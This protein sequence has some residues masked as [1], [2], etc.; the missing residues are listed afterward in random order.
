MFASTWFERIWNYVSSNFSTACWVGMDSSSLLSLQ[1][2]HQKKALVKTFLLSYVFHTW[3]TA[4]IK[5]QHPSSATQ[6][7]SLRGFSGPSSHLKWM[8]DMYISFDRQWFIY[9]CF[10]C[11]PSCSSNLPNSAVQILKKQGGLKRTKEGGNIMTNKDP[12]AECKWVC[13]S[14]CPVVYDNSNSPE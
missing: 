7:T 11:A 3:D 10:N 2:N 1:C 5:Y 13:S 12:V 4:P 14:K 6:E 9:L 8:Q